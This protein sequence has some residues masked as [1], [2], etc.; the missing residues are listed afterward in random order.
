MFTKNKDLNR[1]AFLSGESKFEMEWEA[2]HFEVIQD[3]QRRFISYR[4]CLFDL[5]T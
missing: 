5:K 4:I 2:K 1:L 3:S